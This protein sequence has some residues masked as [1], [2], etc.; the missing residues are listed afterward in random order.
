MLFYMA[1]RYEGGDDSGTPDLELVDRATGKDPNFGY[2]STLLESGIA[3]FLYPIASA[4]VMTRC[5]LGKATATLRL[6]ILNLLNQFGTSSARKRPLRIPVCL[7]QQACCLLLAGYLLLRGALLAYCLLLRGTLLTCLEVKEQRKPRSS[8]RENLRS[9]RE[10]LR[11]KCENLRSKR[12][13]LRS[14][15]TED[16][17]RGGPIVSSHYFY[18]RVDYSIPTCG[19]VG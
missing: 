11:S 19:T 2:L 6:I 14:R 3:N 16:A 8:K 13:N 5:T 17:R 18:P 12:E 10:N 9:K 4:A 7:R 1:V 15:M